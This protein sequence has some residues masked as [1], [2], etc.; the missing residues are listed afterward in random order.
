MRTLSKLTLALI[1][2]LSMTSL[3]LAD[4]PRD[5]GSKA[6][7]EIYNFW[8]GRSANTHA[9]D[10]SRSLYYYGQTQQAVPAPQAQEHVTAV[11]QN[12]NTCQ[13]ALGEL[14]KSNPE[15][16]EAVAAIEKI[17]VIHKKVLSHCD[18]MDKQLTDGKGDSTEICAC[19]SEMH[20]DLDAADTEMDKLMKALKIEKLQPPTK[21]AQP[22]TP[23]KK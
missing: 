19:C 16:K 9:Q 4:T 13:Q 2:G 6:R 18:Q 21:A 15:N 22:A 7:G 10:N 14:K 17:E 23:E 8:V 3:G 20:S 1:V 12:L 5:A 11:R